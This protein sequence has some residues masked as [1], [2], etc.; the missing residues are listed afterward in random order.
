MT[1]INRFFSPMNRLS[2]C[3]YRAWNRIAL[4]GRSRRNRRRRRRSNQRPLV[5]NRRDAKPWRSCSAFLR[6]VSAPGGRVGNYRAAYAS[7]SA[8]ERSA[9]RRRTFRDYA[10]P[11]QR[12]SRGRRSRQVAPHDHRHRPVLRPLAAKRLTRKITSW[13]SDS[14]H[15]MIMSSRRR[16]VN[17]VIQSQNHNRHIAAKLGN[18][19]SG[20]SLGA[21]T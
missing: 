7:L 20:Q 14:S 18:T 11:H 9:I 13:E 5:A 1:R 8:R 4:T 10:R 16:E 12:A 3:D 19:K 21:A 6:P 2:S 17:E 15:S